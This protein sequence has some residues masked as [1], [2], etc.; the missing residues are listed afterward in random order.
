MNH[1]VVISGCSGGGKSTLL[2]ELKQRGHAVIEEP[3]RRIVQQEKLIGGAALPWI[4]ETAFL[5]RALAMALDDHARAPRDSRQWVFFDRGIID[6]AAALEAITGEPVLA[7]IGRRHRYHHYVFMAPPWPEIYAQDVDRLH[8]MK[9][10]QI[11]FERLQNA[12][13]A[14]GYEVALL[15]KT[16]VAERADYVLQFLSDH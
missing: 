12:Y 4:D 16:N 6:A 13:P 10:A 1:F 11:E 7:A 9:A 15:P 5:R 3:G 14:V 2:T 8:D